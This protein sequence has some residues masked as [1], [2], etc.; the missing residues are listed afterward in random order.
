[1]ILHRPL[2]LDE[3]LLVYRSGMRRF[4]P[5]LPEQPIFY[6]VLN[7]HYAEEIARAWNATSGTMAGYVTEFEV[8]DAYARSFEVHQ[9]GARVHQELW[10]PAESLDEFNGN[11]SGQIR[12]IAAYFGPGFV[13]VAPSSFSLRGK[14]ARAQLAVLRGIHEY[15]FMDFHGELTANHE[16]V[17]AHFPYWEQLAGDDAAGFKPVM[18]SIRQVWSGAFPEIRLGLQPSMSAPQ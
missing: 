5:R 7:A 12:L 9:V 2:G 3:L 14:D 17:F 10:I 16:A 4:P 11:I 8:D 1:M 15:S 6:P 13:G 18:A